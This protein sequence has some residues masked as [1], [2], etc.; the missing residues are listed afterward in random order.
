MIRIQKIQDLP[1]LLNRTPYKTTV[2]TERPLWDN[3]LVAFLIVAL[4]GLE[5]ILRRRHDLP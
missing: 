5:W 4:A 3:G 1:S 2:I